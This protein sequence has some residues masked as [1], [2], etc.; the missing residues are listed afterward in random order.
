MQ[1]TLPPVTRKALPSW[2]GMDSGLKAADQTHRIL[3]LRRPDGAVKAL[4]PAAV[5]FSE[6]AMSCFP[7]D[8]ATADTQRSIQ[9]K[10]ERISYNLGSSY[11]SSSNA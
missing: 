7:Q 8:S 9:H 10:K 5:S 1:L 4:W 6:G 3:L 2:L 11:T